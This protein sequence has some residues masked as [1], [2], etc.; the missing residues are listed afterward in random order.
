MICGPEVPDSDVVLV[1]VT[2]AEGSIFLRQFDPE[3]EG[4]TIHRKLGN[5]LP[6]DTT[7]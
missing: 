7:K 3:D 1:V 4:T 6:T 5:Y 2:K